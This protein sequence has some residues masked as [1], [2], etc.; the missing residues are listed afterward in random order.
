MVFL[1]DFLKAFL[2]S[3]DDKMTINIQNNS[4]YEEIINR[5]IAHI[6]KARKY[7]SSRRKLRLGKTRI[8]KINPVSYLL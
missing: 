1:K 4:A 2:N 7:L 6:K 3:V 8:E 5:K